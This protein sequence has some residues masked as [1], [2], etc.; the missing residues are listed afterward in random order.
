MS[1]FE[2]CGHGAYPCA[3]DVD[4][5]RHRSGCGFDGGLFRVGPD[6]CEARGTERR[7]KERRTAES[8]TS[9]VVARC[10]QGLRKFQMNTLVRR[11]RAMFGDSI[12]EAKSII[13]D[14]I[15]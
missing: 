3:V 11:S 6:E 1:E 2:R 15:Q 10:G 9:R 4:S 8:E 7:E 12:I 13:S 5:A 14:S